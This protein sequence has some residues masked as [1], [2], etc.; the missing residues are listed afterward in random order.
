[1]EL[2]VL[3]WL[4]EREP[5]AAS[6]LSPLC[7]ITLWALSFCSTIFSMWLSSVVTIVIHY[8]QKEVGEGSAYIWKVKTVPDF[9]AGFPLC[10]VHNH[11]T[12]HTQLQG[13]AKLL[14]EYMVTKI[15]WPNFR[16]LLWV[17]FLTHP[18]LWL[19]LCLWPVQ[20]SVNNKSC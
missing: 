4:W 11:L 16:W 10:I 15:F 5:D 7:N 8:V 2:N 13:R 19:P 18:Q 20:P 17:L 3:Q 6:S 1:M 9:A 12:C 14:A